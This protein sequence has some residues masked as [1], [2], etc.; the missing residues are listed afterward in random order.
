MTDEPNS[1]TKTK[2]TA[3]KKGPAAS[4]ADDQYQLPVVGVHVPAQFVNLGF[5]GGLAGAAVLGVVDPPL[6]I[7]VGAGVVIARHRTKN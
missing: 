2:V 7:L 5:W 1:T 6:A 3:I 4:G